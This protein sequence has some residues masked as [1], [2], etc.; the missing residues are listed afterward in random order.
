MVSLSSSGLMWADI[1]VCISTATAAC[2]SVRRR[3]R[4]TVRMKG[5]QSG[6]EKRPPRLVEWS[7]K[8]HSQHDWFLHLN[9]SVNALLCI[10][11]LGNIWRRSCFHSMELFSSCIMFALIVVYFVLPEANWRIHRCEWR[12][13]RSNEVV[14]SSRYEEWVKK[15][16]HI[17]FHPYIT[18]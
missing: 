11:S 12:R 4:W 17:V 3:W 7:S 16:I 18:V 5:T 14:E 8:Y 2:P 13:K 9:G 15:Y 10:I 1:I 6:S